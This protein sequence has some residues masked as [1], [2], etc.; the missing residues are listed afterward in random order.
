MNT[1]SFPASL[2]KIDVSPELARILERFKRGEFPLE[3]EGTEGSFTAFLLARLFSAAPGVFLVVTPTEREAEDLA[4]DLETLG[5]PAAILPWWGTI[6]YREMAP[7]SAVFGERTRVLGDLA[8]GRPGIFLVPERAFLTPLPPAEYMRSLLLEVKTGDAID[9]PALARTLVSY[10]YTR[11]PRVQIHGEFALRGEVLDILM[12][13]DEAAVRVLFDFDKVKSIRFFDPSDQVTI[14]KSGQE[15]PDRLLIRPLK[16]VVWTD[17]R[18]LALGRALEEA[19]EFTGNGRAYLEDLM[20]RR[21]TAGEEVLFPLAFESGDGG[22]PAL[23]GYLGRDAVVFYLDRE[24]LENAQESLE[25]EYAGLYRQA[26][27]GAGSARELPLPSRIL[28]RFNELADRAERTVSFMSLKKGAEVS[29]ARL[30]L[31]CEPPRS[32]FGNIDYLNE[33]FGNL[34]GQ[35]WQLV[36]AAES[37]MQAERIRELFMNRDALKGKSPAVEALP[38]SSGFALPAIKLMVVQ[39]NEIFGRRKRAPRSLRQV[40]SAVIDTFVELNPGDYVV[41]VNYGIGHFKGIERIKALGHERDYIKI[42]YLGDEVV[43]VPIEQVN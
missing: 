30:P 3:L 43:F 9:T 27:T 7:L 15:K 6:A 34:L 38:L 11:V 32:F 42:E 14:T 1:L 20:A 2:S 25:R 10:G 39:E 17:E 26:C 18:I 41:H 22:A 29:G 8:L 35:G 31:G 37:E 12:G 13:G 4:G 5:A 24:R 19:G 33:E 16:E 23:T 40:K 21:T 28:L 36:V